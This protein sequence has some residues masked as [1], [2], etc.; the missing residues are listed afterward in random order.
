MEIFIDT[1]N[2][3]EIQKWLEQ[4]VVDGVTTNPSIMLKDGVHD[5][6][7]G[8][9]PICAL[10]GA[11]PVSVEVTTNDHAEMLRRRSEP[12]VAQQFAP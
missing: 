2:R 12:C 10:V 1:S 11:R 8:T 5:L 7:A 3:E 6:Q 9:V 4:G